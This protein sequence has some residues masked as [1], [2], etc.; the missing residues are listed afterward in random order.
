MTQVRVFG[1]T[2]DPANSHNPPYAIHFYSNIDP[3]EGVVSGGKECYKT[4][5]HLPCSS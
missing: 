5:L 3:N 4:Q 2:L 1:I